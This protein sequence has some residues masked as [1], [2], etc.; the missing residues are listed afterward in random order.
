VPPRTPL[1][2]LVARLVAAPPVPLA[3]GWT[4]ALRPGAVV[5]H[6][7]ILGEL[8]RGGFGVVYEARDRRLGRLVAFKAIRPGPPEEGPRRAEWLAR[9]AEAAARL[10]HPNIVTIHDVGTGAAGPY[11]VME[12]L[13]GET[14]RERLDR[15]PVPSAEAYRIIREVVR[16]VAHA[17]ACGVVHRDLKPAN[18]FLRRDGG[19]KVLD[20]GLARILGGGAAPDG[21]TPDYMAPEQEAGGSGDARSDVYSLGMMLEEMLGPARTSRPIGKIAER[22]RQADPGA[23]Y[24]DGREM[25]EALEGGA[26]PM[27][28]RPRWRAVGLVAFLLAS[29]VVAAWLLQRGA[30]GVERVGVAVADVENATGDA[31]LDGI[32]GLLS[33]SLAQSP[34]LTVVPRPRLLDAMAAAGSGEPPVRVDAAAAREHGRRA[35]ARAVLA[36]AVRAEG[37]GLELE[38]RAVSAE[39]GAPLFTV[40]ERAAGKGDVPAALDRLSRST[41]LA[42]RE[43][44]ADVRSSDIRLADA[45]T[46]SLLAYQHYAASQQCMYRTS[47]GQDCAEHLEK[48]LAADP[49]FALAHYQLAVWRAHHGG[50]REEQRLATEAASRH[51]GRVPPKERALIRAWV[52]HFDGRDDEALEHLTAL[53]E[54]NPTDEEAIYEAGDLLYHRSEFEQAAPWFERQ[55]HLDPQLA[56]GWGLEHLAHSLGALG[57]REELQRLALRWSTGPVNAVNLH[58]LATALAWLG[59]LPGAAAAARREEAAGGGLSALEDQAYVAILAGQYDDVRQALGPLTG[60][61]SPA[62]A[63]GYLALAAMDGYQGRRAEGRS[64][65]DAMARELGPAGQDALVRGMRIQYLAGD[66][67]EKALRQEVEGLRALDPEAAAVHAPLLAWLGM[68]EDATRLAPHLRKGSPRQRTLDAVLLWQE[69]RREEGLRRLREIARTSPYDVDFGLAPAFIVADLAARSGADAEAVDGFRRF[70]ALFIPTAMWRSWAHPRSLVL[71]AEALTR[72]GRV[73]EAQEILGRFDAEWSMADDGLPLLARA[74]EVAGQLPAPAAG[75]GN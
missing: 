41:R 10:D 9:E 3:E 8:G 12:R 67:D 74:D 43:R 18:V 30:D 47:F 53:V 50:S 66:G 33:T 36:P 55:L 2:E 73:A 28:R 68:V 22:A 62:R 63:F 4:G 42:L 59:D 69:G 34:H 32:S 56:H 24:R 6:F 51:I 16:G 49:T 39:S 44:D 54:S 45:V 52:A 13:H 61:G 25:L 17:H 35:G 31:E 46:S 19:V 71:E 11:I 14:L 57:R 26:G 20:F 72:L 75:G 48:A 58:A 70:R 5:D 1:S 65:L 37:T 29:V 7:E 23:R 64:R 40:K 38:V 60:P 15:G 27:P 21:G